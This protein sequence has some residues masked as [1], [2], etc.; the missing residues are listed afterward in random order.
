VISN[1]EHDGGAHF[2][3]AKN[4]NISTMEQPILM[5]FGTLMRLGPP[6]TVSQ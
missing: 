5:K 2:K 3:N 4:R 6:D 1:I